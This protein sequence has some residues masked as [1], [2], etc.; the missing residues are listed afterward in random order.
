ML[1]LKT[2]LV[3]GFV[4][5]VVGALRLACAAVSLVVVSLVRD[6]PASH[7]C[8]GL[9]FCRTLCNSDPRWNFLG[10]ARAELT[11]R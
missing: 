7:A 10:G 5:V 6:L 1:Q 8:G 4:I 3:L 2:T 11:D 9:W